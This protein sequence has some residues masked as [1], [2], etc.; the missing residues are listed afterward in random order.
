MGGLWPEACWDRGPVI[1]VS[2]HDVSLSRKIPALLG[3][4]TATPPPRDPRSR[5]GEE[6]KLSELIEDM[7]RAGVKTSLVV[8][9]EEVDEFFSLAARHPGRLFGLA[10]FDSLSPPRGLE[11]VRS[12]WNDHR[13]LI[14]GVRTAMPML[15]QDPRLREFVPL[16]QY[17]LERDLP[18]QFSIG[19]NPQEAATRPTPFGVLAVSYPRL[20]IVCLHAGGPWHPELPGYLRR[21]PNLYAAITGSLG[22]DDEGDGGSRTSRELLRQAGSRQL[23]FGSNWLGRDP[24]YRHAVERMRSLPWWQRRNLCWRTAVRV[25][26]ARILGD[27]ATPMATSPTTR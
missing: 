25:Y 12:L 20:R 11:R 21:F 23:V 27:P 13:D 9:H 14:V 22:S 17:C 3:R 8:I 19:G 7:D 24:A 4:P 6:V 2:V 18:L 15:H 10:Y 5:Q 16:Y 26:G 1:D